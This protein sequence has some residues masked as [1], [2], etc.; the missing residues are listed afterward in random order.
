[1]KKFLVFVIFIPLIF[2]I[3]ACSPTTANHNAIKNIKE[4][5]NKTQS[6]VKMVNVMPEDSLVIPEIMDENTQTEI[7]EGTG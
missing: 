3:T 4:T 1:M 2:I 7:D 5:I 6:I